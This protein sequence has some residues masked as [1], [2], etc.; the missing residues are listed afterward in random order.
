MLENCIKIGL[1]SSNI[2]NISVKMLHYGVSKSLWQGSVSRSYKILLV[3]E[4]DP[5]KVITSRLDRSL[6]GRVICINTKLADYGQMTTHLN[7]FRKSKT[8]IC[9]E[10]TGFSIETFLS[11]APDEYDDIVFKKL[12]FDVDYSFEVFSKS[13]DLAKLFGVA[14]TT[15]YSS[16]FDLSLS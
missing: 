13:A 1:D 15:I 2:G 5:S 6:F 9:G 7:L 10:D 12:V 14:V 16:V 4:D 8:E 11:L 3:N